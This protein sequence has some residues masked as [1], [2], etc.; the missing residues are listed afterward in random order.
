[1]RRE[2]QVRRDLTTQFLKSVP[3][4]SLRAP[5]GTFYAFLKYNH[6]IGS[7]DMAR[8]ALKFG[9]A[10]RPGREFGPNGEGF[11]RISFSVQQNEL[12][13]GLRRLENMLTSQK[14]SRSEGSA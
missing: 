4:V 3:E 12:V 13:E 6:A 8:Q 1:M 14:D 7:V 9:V 11:L 2:Y 5:E 10:V